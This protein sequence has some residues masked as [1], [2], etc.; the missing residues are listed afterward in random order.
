MRRKAFVLI[1]VEKGEAGIVAAELDG[2]AG[3]VSADRVFGR[4]DLVA[5]I[6]AADINGLEK[7]A[8]EIIAPVPYVSR[9]ETLLV[10]SV[11]ELK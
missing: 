2:K 4:C 7:V 3:I 10:I 6:E 5:V 9:T 8:R 11:P 1:E